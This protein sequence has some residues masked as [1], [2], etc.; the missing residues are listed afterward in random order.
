MKTTITRII[1]AIASVIIVLL[2]IIPG[3]I[4]RYPV[5][6][7]RHCVNNLRQIKSAKEMYAIDHSIDTTRNDIV[8]T[9]EQLSTN[10]IKGGYVNL[11]C[12]ESG[13][14]SINPLSKPPTCSFQTQDERHLI[15]Q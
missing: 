9:S 8:L 2:L 3:F 14:Y 6:P 7:Y 5:K 4:P 12:P 10:Y 13:T 15:K 1:L 11:I